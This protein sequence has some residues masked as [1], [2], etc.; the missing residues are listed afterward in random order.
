MVSHGAKDLV[1]LLDRLRSM[2]MGCTEEREEKSSEDP[3]GSNKEGVGE[4]LFIFSL[5]LWLSMA[6][7]HLHFSPL[8][9]PVVPVGRA[10]PAVPCPRRGEL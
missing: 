2:G 9:Q 3:P 1:L 5:F 6:I 8:T 7:G 4:Q 10:V